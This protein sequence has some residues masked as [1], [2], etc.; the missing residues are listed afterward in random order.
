MSGTQPLRNAT[1][2]KTMTLDPLRLR[3][4]LLTG[5]ARVFTLTA[6]VLVASLREY[7]QNAS[8]TFMG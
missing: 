4:L 3:T 5:C 6:N 7:S 2:Y 8:W 1:L